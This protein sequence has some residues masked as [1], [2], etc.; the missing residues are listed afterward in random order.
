MQFNQ[1]FSPSWGV[2]FISRADWEKQNCLNQWQNFSLTENGFCRIQGSTFDLNDL[3]LINQPE[4]K[5]E[6]HFVGNFI[7]NSFLINPSDIPL[8]F[9]SGDELYLVIYFKKQLAYLISL[10]ISVLTLI[11]LILL[12]LIQARKERKNFYL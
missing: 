5:N 1:T 2:Y 11:I 4:L 9:S 8:E 10:I 6:N 12:S 3:G 7:G